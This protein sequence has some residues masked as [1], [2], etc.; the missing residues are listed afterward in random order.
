MF[1]ILLK[2]PMPVLVP[3]IKQFNVAESENVSKT[4]RRLGIGYIYLCCDRKERK[5]KIDF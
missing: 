1:V 4:N 3:K 5:F 2:D